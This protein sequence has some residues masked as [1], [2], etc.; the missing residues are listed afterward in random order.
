MWLNEAAKEIHSKRWPAYFVS[1]DPAPN[2]SN[3]YYVIIPT[4]KEWREDHDAAWYRLA[5]S[6][7]F[8]LHIFE[9]DEDE[10]PMAD[11]YGLA[12]SLSLLRC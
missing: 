9:S 12:P 11:W 2:V 1:F 6:G 4:T 5:K 3:R 8:R 7:T 10:A